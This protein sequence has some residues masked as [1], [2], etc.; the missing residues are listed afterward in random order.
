MYGKVVTF[1]EIVLH[2]IVFASVHAIIHVKPNKNKLFADGNDDCHCYYATI[3]TQTYHA[4]L[5]RV[6]IAA[7]AVE[8]NIHDDTLLVACLA[9]YLMTL[10]SRFQ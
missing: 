5:S 6:P 4:R 8:T 7:H 9:D 2:R 10:K 1:F 3:A